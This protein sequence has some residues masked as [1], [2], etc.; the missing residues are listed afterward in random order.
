MFKKHADIILVYFHNEKYLVVII[1]VYIRL[2]S[3]S[4]CCLMVHTSMK[5]KEKRKLRKYSYTCS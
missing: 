1:L 5:A 3:R 2:M 4:A